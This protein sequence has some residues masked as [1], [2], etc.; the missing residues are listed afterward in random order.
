MRGKAIGTHSALPIALYTQNFGLCMLD[1]AFCHECCWL[2]GGLWFYSSLPL[3][4]EELFSA[5][6][7]LPAA[8][9]FLLLPQ[10]SPMECVISERDACGAPHNSQNKI[11]KSAVLSYYYPHFITKQERAIEPTFKFSF[12]IHPQSLENYTF[13]LPFAGSFLL[14]LYTILFETK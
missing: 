11:K 3:T 8:M 5:A 9:S 4:A 1:S 14:L 13:L 6:A 7:M 12:N 10:G 2:Q